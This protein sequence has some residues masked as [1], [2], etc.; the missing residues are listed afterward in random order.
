MT[1]DEL[2]YERRRWKYRRRFLVATLAGAL[3]LFLVA[4]ILDRSA[5]YAPLAGLATLAVTAYIGAAT[6]QQ[7]RTPGGN[8][9]QSQP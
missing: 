9:A 7:S 5:A 4:L 6:Y 2:T 3:G 1:E 8:G